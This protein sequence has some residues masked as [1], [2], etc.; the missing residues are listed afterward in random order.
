MAG[1]LVGG[2][3]GDAELADARF[4][5]AG[6]PNWV[7]IRFDDDALTPECRPQSMRCSA[8]AAGH[9]LPFA[10]AGGPDGA[11]RLVERF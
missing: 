3:V 11:E 4:A 10:L 9:V 6:R 2:S 5:G 8:P 1:C 7:E